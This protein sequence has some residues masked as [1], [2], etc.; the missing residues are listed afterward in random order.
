MITEEKVNH[1]ADLAKLNVKEEEMEK[2]KKQ[3]SDILT[4]IE[5]IVDVEI[6]DENIM[7]SPT[8]NKNCYNDDI[9]ENHISKSD[10][11]KNA[12]RVRQDYI[13]VPKVLEGEH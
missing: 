13:T 5:K 9:I 6:K 1:I 2:Y 4:E 3:L 12:K 8:T 10:A 7:I 11:L